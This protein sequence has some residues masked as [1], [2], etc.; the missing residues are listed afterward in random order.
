MIAQKPAEIGR[1]AVEYAIKAL[2]GETK[3]LKKRVV[4][5]YTSIDTT[6]VATPE[7]HNAISK[8]T[9]AEEGRR[10]LRRFCTLLS[11]AM[12]LLKMLTVRF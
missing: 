3:G 12:P 10:S 6:T 11:L 9:E 1:I 4:T 5:G 8:D 2:R 7:A